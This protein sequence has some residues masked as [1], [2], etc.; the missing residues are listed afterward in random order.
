MQK[1]ERFIYLIII[2]ILVGFLSA[3][4]TYIIMQ[5]KNNNNIQENNKDN[6]N[7]TNQNDKE[8]ETNVKIEDGVKFVSSKVNNGVVTKNYKI[9]LN[10]KET[11][12]NVEFKNEDKDY[13]EGFL[14]QTEIYGMS[15]NYY[16]K[17]ES[18]QVDKIAE[19]FNENNFKIIQG[20]DG[21]NY[22]IVLVNFSTSLYFY[23]FNDNMEIIPSNISGCGPKD[24]FTLMTTIS[25]YVLEK[26]QKP[27]YQD[28]YNVCKSEHCQIKSKIENNK[29][30]TFASDINKNINANDIGTLEERVY[31]I[32][33]NKLE[34][35][36]INKY[37]I[38][39]GSGGLC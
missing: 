15:K 18:F 6:D 17:P 1:T 26:D 7:K 8:T 5:N 35:E 20:N 19:D 32:N 30:Y 13:I 29:I 14:G 37:K 33:N 31:T 34:Y 38:I 12:I 28:K 22:L 4:A 21:K 27:W 16:E 11:N 3:G 24:T 39:D 9:T 10:G 2:V 36:I 25:N 23:I